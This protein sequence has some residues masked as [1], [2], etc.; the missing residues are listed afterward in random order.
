M[1]GKQNREMPSAM[2]TA[3]N[4]GCQQKTLYGLCPG[5]LSNLTFEA[6]ECFAPK[7]GAGLSSVEHSLRSARRANAIFLFHKKAEKS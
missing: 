1:M 7:V 6:N 4:D 2:L 5:A 3:L